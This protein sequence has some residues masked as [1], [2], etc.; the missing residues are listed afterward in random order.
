MLRYTGFVMVLSLGI[1][2]VGAYLIGDTVNAS[3]EDAKVADVIELWEQD[4][5]LVQAVPLDQASAEVRAAH[6]AHRVVPS[7]LLRQ[8]AIWHSERT[9]GVVLR[10][11]A[12]NLDGEEVLK[13][14]LAFFEVSREIAGMDIVTVAR[15]WTI[16]GD[17]LTGLDQEDQALHAYSS[18]R[19]QLD[20]MIEQLA[21]AR[22]KPSH[23]EAIM[24]NLKGEK[25]AARTI[26]YDT[27]SFPNR[28]IRDS[29][30]FR[31]FMS[32]RNQAA[33]S[34]IRSSAGNLEHLELLRI[35]FRVESQD[36]IDLLEQEIAKVKPVRE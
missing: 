21:I 31:L 6:Q 19:R 29:D 13:R 14:A 33:I 35:H 16:E 18:A 20:D 9:T 1:A 4:R 2:L 8:L 7:G 22:L 25:D 36:I 15:L 26:S 5:R 17:M 12:S 28:L 10:G 32:Y 30:N 27:F 23:N 3:S 24:R 34:M 11:R